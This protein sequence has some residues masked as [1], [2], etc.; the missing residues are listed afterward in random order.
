MRM[1]FTYDAYTTFLETLREH[2]YQTAN[3]KNWQEKKRCVILRHDIDYDIDR[4]VRLAS[5]ER[6]GGVAST[7]FVCLTGNFYNIFS[8]KGNDGLKKIIAKG[9]AIGLH[10]DEL[11]YSEIVEDMEAVKGKILEEADILGRAVGSR[12]DV[13]SMHRPSKKLLEADIDIPGMINS[14][15]K[16]YFQDFK[17]LSDSRRRWREPIDE[18][19]ESEKY[20]RLHILTHAF[21]YQEVESDIRKT[22]VD[23]INGGNCLRFQAM[24]ANISDFNLIMSERDIEQKG[25]K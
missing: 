12:I 15:G 4:A 20:E 21:W 1:K 24:A 22:V 16:I 6:N 9:H 11:Q 2:G 18:I 10:F 3:Y 8:K 17:Y 13:V 25:D 19:V 14:Y 5:I 7:Y 23:F